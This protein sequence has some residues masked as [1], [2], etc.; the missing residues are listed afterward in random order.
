MAP[1]LADYWMRSK[2]IEE[3]RRILDAAISRRPRDT[4]LRLVLA[5]LLKASGD[6]AGSEREFRAVLAQDA[7]SEEALEALVSLLVGAGRVD[8]AA[9][10]SLAAAPRQPRNQENSLRAARAYEARGDPK[11]VVRNL[12]AAEVS[13]PVNATFE[14]TLALDLYKLL[15]MDEMM[16]RLAEAR[17]LSLDEGSAGVT[18]SIDALIARMR[19]ETAQAARH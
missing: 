18:S 11:A 9:A 8:E 12:L 4:R 19:L 3:G 13:G 1:V 6:A 2:R 15:R 5:G 17:R 14:L 16:L 10:E 7:S